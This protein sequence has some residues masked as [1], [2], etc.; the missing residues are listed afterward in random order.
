MTHLTIAALRHNNAQLVAL[1]GDQGE[2]CGSHE[3]AIHFAPCCNDI[4]LARSVWGSCGD[5]V[6]LGQAAGRVLHALSPGPCTAASSGP[7]FRMQQSNQAIQRGLGP[8][9]ALPGSKAQQ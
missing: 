4:Q 3:C 1:V 6:L 2:G 9:K 7:D 8:H 5:N